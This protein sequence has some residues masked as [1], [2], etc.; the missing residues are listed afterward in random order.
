MMTEQQE[1]LDVSEW[2][3]ECEREKKALTE[4]RYELRNA[5]RTEA[6]R[7]VDSLMKATYI[8]VSESD[9]MTVLRGI[10]TIETA[11]ENDI[12]VTSATNAFWDACIKTV[13]SSEMRCRVAVVGNSS[14]GKTSGTPV[15]IRKLLEQKTAVVYIRRTDSKEGWHYEFVPTTAGT[16][17]AEVYPEKTRRCLI[18][19]L[20]LSSTYY[21]VD[22]GRTHDSCDPPLCFKPKVLILAPLRSRHWGNSSFETQR[23]TVQG[24]LKYFPLW[25]LDDVLAAQPILCPDI[26][27]DTM[28]R[29]YRLFGGIPG[30]VFTPSCHENTLL[31][32]QERAL[33]ELSIYQQNHSKNRVK[34]I[35]AGRM[36]AMNC[37][38][39]VPKETLMGYIP[40]ID[41]QG[42]FDKARPTL[43]S[44]SIADKLFSKHIKDLWDLMVRGAIKSKL[45]F[46]SYIRSLVVDP[47]KTQLTFRA[48][49]IQSRK[50]Q[51][52]LRQGVSTKH[53]FLW[54]NVVI[55][56]CKE[57]R[58]VSDPLATVTNAE[59]DPYILF[60]AWDP[61][62]EE[63]DYAFKDDVGR[64]YILTTYASKANT[65]WMQ[66]IATMVQSTSSAVTLY[67]LVPSENLEEVSSIPTVGNDAAA[68][69]MWDVSVPRPA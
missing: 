61:S 28:R 13:E 39:E 37:F 8:K 4:R 60:H 35:A 24:C 29:R 46:A 20:A 48:R 16:F 63:T 42:T 59:S 17:T 45:V 34:R 67:N 49:Q 52:L 44:Y 65:A 15:L 69:A 6:Q 5:R 33:R 41:D 36:D 50:G 56:C 40:A 43:I 1:I 66:H 58:I 23:H 68:F 27:K 9:G 12:V 10:Y 11:T 14:I 32:Y 62:F 26:T 38:G 18:P 19:S 25:S 47:T 64:I 51:S 57:A 7:F 31:Q 3:R 2:R 22:P 30:D 55:P 53:A 54:Q 21:I